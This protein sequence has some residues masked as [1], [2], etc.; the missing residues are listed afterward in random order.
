V[1][2]AIEYIEGVPRHEKATIIKVKGEREVI[3][4]EMLSVKGYGKQD[5]G[6]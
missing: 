1:E 3:L 5:F 4:L 2:R 6:N